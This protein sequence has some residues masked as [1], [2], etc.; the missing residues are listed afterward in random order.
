MNGGF[1][2]TD[3][4]TSKESIV[5]YSSL[6]AYAGWKAQVE[7]RNLGIIPSQTGFPFFVRMAPLESPD[8]FGNPS[9]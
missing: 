5:D 9:E 2:C 4:R 1:G 8:N 7:L 3:D 6:K